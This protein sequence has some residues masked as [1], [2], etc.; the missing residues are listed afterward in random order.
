MRE[1]RRPLQLLS[2]LEAEPEFYD[3]ALQ[4][5]GWTTADFEPIEAAF[6]EACAVDPFYIPIYLRVSIL[7]NGEG[8]RQG[9]A[10]KPGAWL[11]ETLKNDPGDPE[12]VRQKKIVTYAQTFGLLPADVQLDPQNL[13]WPTLKMGL[14]QL[15]P[16][17]QKFAR[18]A[19]PMSRGRLH[20][21][22]RRSGEGSTGADSRELQSGRFFGSCRLPRH[23]PLGRGSLE[24]KMQ[25]QET[26]VE[27]QPINSL[28]NLTSKAQ[29]CAKLKPFS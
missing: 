26:Q 19:E 6:K 18:L 16:G 29:D 9:G 10:P 24:G 8:L 14:F 21:P 23:Q 12:P 28:A 4:L 15:A 13:D 3:V 17:S 1:C 5:L 2:A 20:F 25:S 7:L 27:S 11:T 22:G